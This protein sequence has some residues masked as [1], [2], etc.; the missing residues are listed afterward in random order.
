MF[1]IWTRLPCS[2][3]AFENDCIEATPF[4]Q[5]K[6]AARNISGLS[7]YAATSFATAILARCRPAWLRE[8]I[9]SRGGERQDSES[10]R[11]LAELDVLIS[12]IL[13]DLPSRSAISPEDM[14][15]HLIFLLLLHCV[16]IILHRAIMDR[17][18]QQQMADKPY[19]LISFK[20]CLISAQVMRDVVAGIQNLE[21]SPVGFRR[22]L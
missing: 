20:R 18:I 19:L 2:E 22:V 14:I 17:A 5:E 7:L 8:G 16:N 13:L 12:T 3:A 21:S 11:Y 4:L 10:E 15:K 1:Q 6:F 9:V